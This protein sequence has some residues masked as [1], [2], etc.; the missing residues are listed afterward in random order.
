MIYGT[1]CEMTIDERPTISGRSLIADPRSLVA[2]E[3]ANLSMRR[4]YAFR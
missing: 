2:N 4:D 1:L 3:I